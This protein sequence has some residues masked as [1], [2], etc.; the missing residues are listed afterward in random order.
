M[1][2]KTTWFSQLCSVDVDEALRL[3]QDLQW[4]AD[5]GFDNTN[6]S[7]D[8]NIVVEVF[9]GENNNNNEFGNIIHR[10]RQLFSTSFNFKV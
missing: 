6:F 7:L 9:N 8:S 10:C 2:A 4:V 5:L 1:L 3:S